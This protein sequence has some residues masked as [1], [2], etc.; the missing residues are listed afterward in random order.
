MSLS[1]E[2]IEGGLALVIGD[3]GGVRGRVVA[4]CEGELGAIA[5]DL[6]VE[7]VIEGVGADIGGGE[8]AGV[9]GTHE[10]GAVEEV[11]SEAAAV[12]G[13]LELLA[14]G[15]QG[16][17]ENSPH[18]VG[19]AGPVLL[20]AAVELHFEEGVVEAPAGD[21]DA[22]EVEV[23]GDLGVVLADEEEVDSAELIE[24]EAEFSGVAACSHS[25]RHINERGRRMRRARPRGAARAD[26]WAFAHT[27]IEGPLIYL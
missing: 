16:G 10:T 7:E 6:F 1:E 13:D 22:V 14:E 25:I 4:G 12:G 18:G 8:G 19:G 20:A 26:G 15:V 2:T 21:G 5:E 24:G 27:F 3:W 23:L 11:E 17:G 9:G